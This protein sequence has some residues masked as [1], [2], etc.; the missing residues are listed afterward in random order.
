MSAVINDSRFSPD[1]ENTIALM[2]NEPI[3][4]RASY[5]SLSRLLP[6]V[7]Q[8]RIAKG[9]VLY[10]A[11]EAAGILYFVAEGSMRLLGGGDSTAGKTPSSGV[12]DTVERGYIG[13]EAILGS[14]IYMADAIAGTDALLVAIPR[15]HFNELLKANPTI[16][17]E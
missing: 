10:R 14:E 5:E 6:H 12:I 4:S 1:T 13:E 3:V 15:E 7:S 2:K 16:K 17:S 8:R 9:G 11:G